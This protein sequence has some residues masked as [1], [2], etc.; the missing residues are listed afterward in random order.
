YKAVELNP[1]NSNACRAL[2][3]GLAHTGNYILAENYYKKAIEL[4]EREGQAAPEPYLDLAYLLLFSNQKEPPA[5]ALD[6]KR[7]AIAIN[8]KIVDAHYVWGKALLKLDGYSEANEELLIATRLNA[9]DGRPYLL[10]AQVYDRLGNT[11]KA[12]EARQSFARLNQHRA[13]ESDAI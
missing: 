11:A 10:L 7:N 3:Q 8:S 6:Y 2:G 13:D 1:R 4:A 5:R 12:R 9:K